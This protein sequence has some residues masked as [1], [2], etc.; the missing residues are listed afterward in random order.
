MDISV[1]RRAAQMAI[2]AFGGVYGVC[3]YLGVEP[4]EVFNW[5]SSTSPMPRE[6]F[7]KIIDVICDNLTL[8][9]RDAMEMARR[10]GKAAAPSNVEALLKSISHRA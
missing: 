4:E 3:A 8:T 1:Q 7:L 9:E 2:D 5:M 6:S 10:I